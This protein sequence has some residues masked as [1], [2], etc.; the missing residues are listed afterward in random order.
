MGEA[1]MKTM[2]LKY[3]ARDAPKPTLCRIRSDPTILKRRLLT[4]NDFS[5]VENLIRKRRRFENSTR[6]GS[7]S[8]LPQASF[9]ADAKTLLE[10]RKRNTP[11]LCL[12]S[13]NHITLIVSNLKNSV[14]FYQDILGLTLA[15]RPNSVGA[16]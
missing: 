7:S 11:K 14:E 9:Q 4:S 5:G 8:V 12:L 6:T 3:P 1:A 10:S 16:W 2:L 13:V 15:N